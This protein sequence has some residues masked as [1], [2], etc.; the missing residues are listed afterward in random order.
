MAV[1]DLRVRPAALGAKSAILAHWASRTRLS[2]TAIHDH[3]RGPPPRPNPRQSALLTR[4]RGPAVGRDGVLRSE[5][6]RAREARLLI[7]ARAQRAAAGVR[8]A[9]VVVWKQRHVTS[10][11]ARLRAHTEPRTKTRTHWVH[12]AHRL[13]GLFAPGCHTCSI[14]PACVCLPSTCLTIHIANIFWALANVSQWR[15]PSVPPIWG[16]GRNENSL[17]LKL[18]ADDTGRVRTHRRTCPRWGCSRRCM[19][20]CSRHCC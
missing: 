16:T 7:G 5:R 3:R 2:N 4:A 12:H 1:F 20:T 18:A 13:R 17:L 15:W 8:R 14:A 9:L 10:R 6:T 19:C 11:P